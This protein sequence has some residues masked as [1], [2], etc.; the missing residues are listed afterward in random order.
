MIEGL[1][2][3]F[4]P[5]IAGLNALRDAEKRPSEE[6]RR[7]FNDH[8]EVVQKRMEE[9]QKDYTQS[10]LLAIA[11]LKDH[12]SLHKVVEVLRSER[13]IALARRTEVRSFLEKLAQQRVRHRPIKKDEPFGLFYE[14][15]QAVE[16]YLS[17]ASPLS[18]GD[19]WYSYFIST[20]S[21][22]VERGQNPFEYD[23]Y[24]IAGH[25]RSAPDA[26]RIQLERA[27]FDLMPEA[28]S[29]LANAYGELRARF[30][31]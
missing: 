7:F 15:V 6:R 16:A 5:L 30:L 31:T 26:A 20:F 17:A 4:G 9:I 27:V 12:V 23:K 1:M 22:L 29:R 10:F 11:G 8:I 28:W 3:L 14:Y 13:P 24:A 18:P 2:G 25:E 21:Q 19:T